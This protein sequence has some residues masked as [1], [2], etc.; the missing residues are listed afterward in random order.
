MK[1]VFEMPFLIFNNVN[2]GFLDRE[3]TWRTYSIAK[4]LLT[5]K[6]IKIIDWKKFAKVT[7][8]LNKEAFVLYIATITLGMTIH[9]KRKAHIALLKAKEAPVS[10]PAEYLDFAD[11]FS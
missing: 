9:P 10:V 4:A 2:V 1:V 7:L 3:P 8:N 11:V 6:K 5:T